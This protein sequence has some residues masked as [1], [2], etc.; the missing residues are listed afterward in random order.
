MKAWFEKPWGSPARL[1]EL[2]PGSRGLAILPHRRPVPEGWS[3]AEME[4][5]R[6]DDLL[7]A[8][9]ETWNAIVI[10]DIPVQRVDSTV[11]ESLRNLSAETVHVHG[12]MCGVEQLLVFGRLMDR[13]DDVQIRAITRR[14]MGASSDAK[15]EV[16]RETR[17]LVPRAQPSPRRYRG[18]GTWYRGH[19]M[20]EPESVLR[21]IWDARKSHISSDVDAYEAFRRIFIDV[22]HSK[23]RVWAKRA[24]QL[25]P[26]GAHWRLGVSGFFEEALDAARLLERAMPYDGVVPD[27]W[28]TGRVLTMGWDAVEVGW[29]RTLVPGGLIVAGPPLSMAGLAAWRD[30]RRAASTIWRLG[31][32]PVESRWLKWLRRGRVP[33]GCLDLW[34]TCAKYASEARKK[35]PLSSGGLRTL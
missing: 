20:A 17:A 26:D 28:A 8:T 13:V 27:D 24:L 5:G 33:D 22:S 12:P 31:W 32:G 14:W 29:G 30:A 7:S 3:V 25:E 15:E 4:S 16:L 9:M 35:E 10:K 18:W 2:P 23:C 1:P 6:G 34:R 21:G 19:P 11:G